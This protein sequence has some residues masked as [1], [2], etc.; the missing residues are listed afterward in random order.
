M[1]S[2]LCI[3]L[4]T[5]CFHAPITLVNILLADDTLKTTVTVSEVNVHI[6]R[7]ISVNHRCYLNIQAYSVKYGNRYQRQKVSAE[8]LCMYCKRNKKQIPRCPDIV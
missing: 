1:M 7:P 2:P 4:C 8:E 5:C 3:K 6:S